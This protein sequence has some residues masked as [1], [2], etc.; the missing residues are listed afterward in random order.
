MLHLDTTYDLSEDI[1]NESLLLDE[2]GEFV[3]MH[4]PSDTLPIPYPFGSVGT[5]FC[6]DGG[7]SAFVVEV[8]DN[9][10]NPDNPIA[11]LLT[12]AHLIYDPLTGKK[13]Q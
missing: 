1:M 12:A 6:P 4:L 13:D 9:Q 10:G 3:K 2:K 8:L 7:G 11:V 5:L